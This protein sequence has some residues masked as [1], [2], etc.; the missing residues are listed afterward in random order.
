[1][2]NLKNLFKIVPAP[3]Q[4]KGLPNVLTYSPA[5]KINQYFM[6]NDNKCTLV[7][8]LEKEINLKLILILITC[9][10]IGDILQSQINGRNH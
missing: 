2:F 4:L 9:M 5:S 6:I 10:L 1:M 3:T 8:S 7:I